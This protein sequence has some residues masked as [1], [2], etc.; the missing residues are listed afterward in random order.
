MAKTKTSNA[1]RYRWQKKAY[2]PIKINVPK[3]RR[4]DIQRFVQERGTSVNSF[5]NEALRMALGMTEE[6]W[7]ARPVQA[8]EDGDEE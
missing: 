7:A 8:D 1:V 2:Y 4:E 5:V 3:G 6:E